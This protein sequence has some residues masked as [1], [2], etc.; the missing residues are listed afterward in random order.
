MVRD[1]SMSFFMFLYGVALL[2]TMAMRTPFHL[3]YISLPFMP[4]LHRLRSEANEL[5]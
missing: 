2:Q 3:S 5:T 4:R 1:I